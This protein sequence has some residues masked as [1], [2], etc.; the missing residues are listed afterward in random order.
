VP[1]EITTPVVVCGGRATVR[2]RP[3][4]PCSTEV[5]DGGAAGNATK[6][7]LHKQRRPIS[8]DK[9]HTRTRNLSFGLCVISSIIVARAD[10]A[11][12]IRLAYVDDRYVYILLAPLMSVLLTIGP[13]KKLPLVSR[14]CPKLGIPLALSGIVLFLKTNR[15]PLVVAGAGCQ[16]ITTAAIVLFWAGSFISFYGLEG[17]QISLAP[18]CFLSLVVPLPASLLNKLVVFMQDESAN[19]AN[20][21]F[22]FIG[23]PAFRNGFRFSLPGIDIEIAKQC[24]GIRSAIALVLANSLAAHVMLRSYARKTFVAL[25]SIPFVICK[26]A[27]RIVTL[28]WLGVYVDKDFLYGK[29]HRNSG[30]VFSVLDVVALVAVLTML[31]RSEGRA[32]PTS[33]TGVL[34]TGFPT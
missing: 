23:L 29:L 27:I 34:R 6:S 5:R 30:L 4:D 26:N 17:F 15:E 19:V 25:F 11:A 8:S 12:L 3:P 20:I 22:Q 14:Y 32:G 13:A 9:N 21:L 31:Q 24:S 33:S 16:P 18:W 7:P 2:R 28:S 10:L 1:I